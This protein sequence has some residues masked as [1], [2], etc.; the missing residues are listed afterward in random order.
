MTRDLFGE[1]PRPAP[2]AGEIALAMVLHDQTDKAWLL[3]ETNDRREA[4][5]A[6]KSQARRGEGRDENI[7]TMPT[8]LAQE[9]GWM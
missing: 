9:R 3:A 8:W 5:W 4:Q 6:P 2:K 7:W 1:T